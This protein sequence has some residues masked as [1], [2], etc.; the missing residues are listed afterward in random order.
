MPWPTHVKQNAQVPSDATAKT[1]VDVRK[2]RLENNVEHCCP[3]PQHSTIEGSKIR[4][5]MP[6]PPFLL[7][8]LQLRKPGRWRKRVKQLAPN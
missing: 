7:Q 1:A 2:Y 8:P 6:C 4:S 5:P 3:P